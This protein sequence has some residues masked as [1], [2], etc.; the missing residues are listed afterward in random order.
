[1]IRVLKQS[2]RAL[3]SVMTLWGGVYEF[4]PDILALAPEENTEITRTGDLHPDTFNQ[5]DHRCHTFRAQ[6]LQALLEESGAT[7]LT[8]SGSNC[9]SAEGGD[10]LTEVRE[11]PPRWQEPLRQGVEAC[12]EPGCVDMGTHLI[13]VVR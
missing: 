3:F 1:M 7:V 11:D 8:M 6:K 5:C 12:R 4:L 9:L 13:A 10:R 2:G